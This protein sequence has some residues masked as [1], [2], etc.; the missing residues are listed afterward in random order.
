MVYTDDVELL[1]KNIGATGALREW[2]KSDR[3]A[4]LP[5]Y[6]TPEEY[7]THRAIFSFPNGTYTPPLN[8]YR[9]LLRG[10]NI[11]DDETIPKDRLTTTQPLLFVGSLTDPIGNALMHEGM[12][13]TF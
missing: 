9:C 10:Y 5:S 8:W 2:V 3:R 1:K 4:P 6:L 7:A 12:I 13:K 11:S